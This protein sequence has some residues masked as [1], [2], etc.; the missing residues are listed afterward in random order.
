MRRPELLFLAPLSIIAS[1]IALQAHEVHVSSA[2]RASGVEA[3][4]PKPAS[5]PVRHAAVARSTPAPTLVSHAR[6]AEPSSEEAL[7][8]VR[9]AHEPAPVRDLGL[10]RRRLVENQAG[11]YIGDILAARD[12]NIARWPDRTS[13]PLRV[14]IQSADSA[15]DWNPNYV[16]QVRDAFTTWQAAGSPVSFTFVTDSGSAD[17]HV[18]WV[19]HFEEQ[20][21]GKTL[22]ARDE[23]WWIVDANIA[24]ALHHNHGEPLDASAVRAIAL[25]EI[26]HLLG[27]DHS[28]DTTNI[29]TARVRVRDLSAAD[30][31]TMRLVY[32]LPPGSVRDAMH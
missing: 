10:I 17:T 24:I 5:D 30:M 7:A 13:R 32:T 2:G 25:H 9:H 11:T 12:S 14:W 20:I 8:T 21:S 3:T 6:D 4:E 18:T 31:A 28:A 27:L 1:W 19:D 15:H 23:N 16:A 29:M 22:W 26:G